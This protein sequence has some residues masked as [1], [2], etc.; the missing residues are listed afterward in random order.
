MAQLAEPRR[1]SRCK[2]TTTNITLKATY[3]RPCRN[4]YMVQYHK[5]KPTPKPPRKP[6]A[7]DALPEQDRL[8]LKVLVTNNV[9]LKTIAR[10]IHVKYPTLCSWKRK[11]LLDNL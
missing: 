9:P 7:V 1:C 4:A 2:Q 10:A 5:D 11:K 8:V 3:C 6:R